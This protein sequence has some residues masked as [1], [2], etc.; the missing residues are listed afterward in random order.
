MKI[1]READYALRIV[2]MLSE[3]KIQVEAKQ[4]ADA[5][6]IPYRFTLKIL[7]KLVQ[8]DIVKSYRGV[9][10]GYTIKKSPSE[11]TLKEVIE[12]IDGPIAINRCMDSPDICEASVDCQ[13]KKRLGIAQQAFSDELEKVTFEMILNDKI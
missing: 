10:G 13:L 6:L 2:C 12:I 4:I 8:A 3:Q 11:I 9:N 5:K 1:T 7:R